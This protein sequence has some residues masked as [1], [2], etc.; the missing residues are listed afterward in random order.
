MAMWLGKQT[1]AT[2]SL[3][4]A[5]NQTGKNIYSSCKN[6]MDVLPRAKGK[7]RKRGI[8]SLPSGLRYDIQRF[9]ITKRAHSKMKL[10][11]SEGKKNADFGACISANP[12]FT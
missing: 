3:K 8:H 1:T 11:L 9:L 7:V 2:H 5:I 10:K 4:I 6:A 12:K